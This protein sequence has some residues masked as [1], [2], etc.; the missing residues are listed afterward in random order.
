MAEQ[1]DLSTQ[2]VSNPDSSDQSEQLRHTL[3]N[4]AHLE[5]R[6]MATTQLAAI[7]TNFIAFTGLAV[8]AYTTFFGSGAGLFP[9]AQAPETSKDLLGRL[10]RQAMQIKALEQQMLTISTSKPGSQFN[11][12]AR[13][14][15]EIAALTMQLQA[16]NSAI[17]SSPEKSLAIPLL[18]KDIDATA[19]RLEDIQNQGRS[20]VNR[21][22]DQQKWM[23]GGI[24]AV[25]LAIAG[26]A[27][28]IILR[29]L[30]TANN[31]DP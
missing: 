23:L 2:Q 16:L 18:R 5:A 27:T 4:L 15:A 7:V 9:K 19:K 30:P 10:D 28:T 17:M 21:L 31:N 11:T 29:T 8:M 6:R 12:T 1:N 24:G 26:G 20:E 13:N 14:S 3:E 25:L 22:Y